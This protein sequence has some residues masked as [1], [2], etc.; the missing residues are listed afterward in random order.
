M[1][2]GYPL[3]GWAPGFEINETMANDKEEISWSVKK[4][5]FNMRTTL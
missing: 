5:Q 1:G 3:F 2:Y 4:F